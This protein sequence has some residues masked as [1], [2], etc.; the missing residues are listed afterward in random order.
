VGGDG[1]RAALGCALAL[2][3]NDY[4]N[5]TLTR[6]YA[7]HIAVLPAIVFGLVAAHIWLARRHGN[8]SREGSTG[9]TPRWPSQTL[10]DVIAMAVAF[11]ILLGYVISQQGAD[12]Q[13][14]ADPANAFDARPL[15]YFR[16]LFLLRE[17][18]G[19]AEKLVAMA[20]PAIVGGILVALPLVDR[21]ETTSWK[22]RIPFVGA[23][24][25]LMAIIGM[26]TI[27]SVISD[28]QDGKHADA[29]AKSDKL[30]QRA[31]ELA[32][33][34]GVPVTGALDVYS[35]P[36]MYRA[37][38]LFEQRCK[39]CH[40]AKST[41]RKGPIIGPGHGNRAWLTAFIKAPSSDPY[42][43]HTTLGKDGSGMK[44]QELAKPQLDEVVEF[45]YGE[46]GATD[47]DAKKRDAGQAT[48]DSACNDCHSHDEGNSGT[49][50]NLAGLGS[51]AY[52]F[53]FISNPKSALHMGKASSEMPRFDKE[54]SVA[55]R[56]AIAGYLFWLTSASQKDLD[57]LG[58]L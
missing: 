33:A 52:Y 7:L 21:S 46:S 50:P 28:G 12:L 1:L 51:R 35:T 29:L 16:W 55:D 57:A 11:A 39:S 13:G 48:F 34:N 20:V 36:P 53:D 14:P 43:G 5:L 40:D 4:G 49:S 18:A 22:K 56:D 15:W 38:T 3:G 54:L 25:G 27:V 23:A 19:S 10:R 24:V 9:V 47:V 26:L 37:R 58:A 45:L 41:D 6:F 8:T 31:R 2:G 44:P 42:W 30:A 32:V 17:L